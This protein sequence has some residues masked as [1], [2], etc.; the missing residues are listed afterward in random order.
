MAN[1]SQVLAV[2]TSGAAGR[3]PTGTVALV[4]A[5][6]VAIHGATSQLV[7]GTTYLYTGACTTRDT[8][9][10][11]VGTGG[12]VGSLYLSTAGKL[13]LKVAAAGATTD[14]QKVTATAA[15]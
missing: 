2:S 4:N 5:S 3:L 1:E 14:W 9:R 10:A 12:A 6:G 15:D 8:V 11:E 7:A 13:Y